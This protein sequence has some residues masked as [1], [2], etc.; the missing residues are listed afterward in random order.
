MA[1]T[2]I[3]HRAM[4][5][6]LNQR[7]WKG[8]A[9]DRE[10][11]AQAELS[12]GAEMGTMTV[13][14]QLAPK[15]LIQP[16][17]TIKRLG[18]EEHYKMTVPGLFRGQALLPTKMFETY[19]LT[20]SEIKDQF[21]KA[22]DAFD[23]VYPSI[24]T[25][26]KVKLGTAFRERD[27]PTNIKSLFGYDIQTAPVPEV[28]DW[29]LDGVAPAD[30]ANLRSE[31]EDSVRKMYH[32]ATMTMFERARDML[33]NMIRQAKGF[34]PKHPGAT[35]GD[36]TIEQI[37]E[38]ASLFCDMNITG[39]PTLDKIGKEMLR[40]FADLQGSEIRKSAEMRTDIATK[41]AKILAKMST[42]KR[43]AA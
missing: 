14:K 30:V 10:V 4:L 27:F 3:S 13:I 39:D 17:N 20:Q 33:E 16:I 26:A 38:L 28:N 11:A 6:A 12:A 7:A 32:D 25:K 41:A 37:K 22:V 15:H 9:S 23:K 35:L 8:A 19:M 31:V 29:R 43:I 24:V 2:P 5:V 18:R 34:N 1:N 40:D 21:F 36:P 42:T